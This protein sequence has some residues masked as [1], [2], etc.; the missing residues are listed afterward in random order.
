MCQVFFID[1][2]ADLRLAIE[3]TFE[4]ADIEAT[5]FSDAESALLAMKQSDEAGV[6]VTDICLPGIS[7]MDLLTT[8][9]QRDPNLPVIM[10]TGHGDI[11]MAVNALHQG[12]YDFIEKPFAPE[13]LVETVK[14]AIERRQLTNENEK[15]RQSLKASQT[16]GPRIIGETTSIQ[17]LRETITHIADTDA[18]ILLF[19]E[20]GTGKELI[21][22]SL[23]EQSSRR[24][25]NFVAVNCGAVPENLIESE[26]YG[27]EKG[28][29]TGADS[30][31]IGKFE[32]A[33]GGTLF[34]DE[35]E[36]MPI[37]A[38]IR[39]LR[40]LQERVIERVGSNELLPLDIRVVA[41]TK[42]DLKRAAEQGTF[43]QD[44][45]YRLNVVTLDLPPLRERKEDIPALFHHFLLVA[46]SR[47][48]KS[49]PSLSAQDL[50]QLMA[51]DWPGNVRE[52]RNA[53]ERFVL[54]GKLIQLGEPS[55][56]PASTSSLA[57]QVAE[58][59]KATIE[60]ALLENNG[61]IKQ[62]MEQLNVPRKTLYD[63]M[64]RYQIDKELYK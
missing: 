6:I 34:L 21:A 44:L 13:H 47:Y 30:R 2:E 27:H 22:R 50:A 7:G 63:K 28:A 24:N 26:L 54:L 43:R 19:G 25:N 20:T 18:D 56:I 36:S 9:V 16:L 11:S 5:F 8:L 61:S 45:Y 60:N 37:Q 48:G 46:A 49:S 51:H 58:F 4:L 17:T 55:S 42:V 59:E 15:L 31:R 41:A 29:F 10:I 35:I 33:Q 53:A 32:F 64:Q 57:E 12:A 1:D 38:Q 62:T 23:H 14:R 52:L 39:L 3:Q 40:V